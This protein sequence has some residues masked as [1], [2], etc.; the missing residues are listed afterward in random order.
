MPPPPE[1]WEREK[2]IYGEDKENLSSS[3]RS[4]LVE[5]DIRGDKKFHYFDRDAW[6][7]HI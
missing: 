6:N 7:F 3:D 1:E 5:E 4:I 2:I